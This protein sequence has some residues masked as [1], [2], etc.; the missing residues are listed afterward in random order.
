MFADGLAAGRVPGIRAIRAGLRCG[1]PRA[2]QVQAYLRT[3]ACTPDVAGAAEPPSAV[4]A[5]L[6]GQAR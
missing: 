3:L 4:P 1:Q 5:T 2:N 6:N